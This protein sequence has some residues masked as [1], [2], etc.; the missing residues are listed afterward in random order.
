MNIL[1]RKPGRP[2]K[3]TRKSR[4]EQRED[5]TW[6]RK[7]AEAG[8]DPAA[9]AA[10]RYDQVRAAV[11]RLRPAQRAAAWRKVHVGLDDLLRDIQTLSQ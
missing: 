5:A 7:W 4:R 8:D 11:M 10:V 3:S 2:V 6:R 9:Q 1:N